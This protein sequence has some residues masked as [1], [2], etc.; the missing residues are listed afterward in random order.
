M[1]P[2]SPSTSLLSE[3]ITPEVLQT[4]PRLSMATSVSLS[5]APRRR[6]RSLRWKRQG[7]IRVMAAPV[8]LPVRP[9]S[10]ENLGTSRAS[11]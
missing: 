2:Y 9:I 1:W 6:Q 11:R 10:R 5:R 7:R 8:T 3:Q 4:S